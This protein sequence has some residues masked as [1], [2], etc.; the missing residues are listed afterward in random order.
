MTCRDKK[1]SVKRKINEKIWCAIVSIVV[2]VLEAIF[3]YNMQLMNIAICKRDFPE[4]EINIR[5]E[6]W[7][8]LV[9]SRPRLLKE[10]INEQVSD[11][12][13]Y[14]YEK[15]PFAATGT[16]VIDQMYPSHHIY[17]PQMGEYYTMEYYRKILDLDETL[18]GGTTVV[19]WQRF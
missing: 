6:L 9:Y 4:K 5:K 12:R 10:D 3:L 11:I 19:A 16:I 15:T 2:L 17:A 1:E 8:E 18:G 14:V 7:Q 13:D